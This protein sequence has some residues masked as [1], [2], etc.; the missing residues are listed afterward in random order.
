MI[1]G[2][3][4]PASPGTAPWLTQ[5]ATSGGCRTADGG[6]KPERSHN[7]FDM[8]LVESRGYCPALSLYLTLEQ[9]CTHMIDLMDSGGFFNSGVL[10]SAPVISITLSICYHGDSDTCRYSGHMLHFY[11]NLQIFTCIIEHV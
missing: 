1:F 2:L 3:V 6:A 5:N 10:A 7:A 4:T 9:Q 8:C 11:L